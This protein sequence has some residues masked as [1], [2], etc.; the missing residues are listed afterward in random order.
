[1]I[2]WEVKFIKYPITIQYGKSILSIYEKI[3]NSIYIIK[4]YLAFKIL[5]NQ[6]LNSYIIESLK[7]KYPDTKIIYNESNSFDQKLNSISI[8][9]NIEDNVKKIKKSNIENFI[10]NILVTTKNLNIDTFVEVKKCYESKLYIRL[11]KSKEL[12]LNIDKYQKSIKIKLFLENNQNL[13]LNIIDPSNLKFQDIDINYKEKKFQIKNNKLKICAKEKNE[14]NISLKSENFIKNG[15]WNL[16]FNEDNKSKYMKIPFRLNEKI[17]NNLEDRDFPKAYIDSNE[18]EPVF[19]IYYYPNYEEQLKM[20]ENIFKF[21]KLS[22]GMGI[23]FVQKDRLSEIGKLYSFRYIYKMQKYVK[24][25]QLTN[26]SQGIENGYTANEEIG[27]NYFKT[28]P[29]INLDGKGVVISIVNSGINYL[30][31]DFIYPDG[32]SKIL[33]LWDQTKD[34]NPPEGFSIGTEYTR[35]EIN[36]AIAEKNPNL[37]TDEEGIGTAL[38]GVCAGLGNSNKA[39]AGVAEGADLIVVK[40]K[41]IN[42]FYNNGTFLSGIDYSYKK[43][44]KLDM[45]IV[46]NITLGSNNLLSPGIGFMDNDLFYEY[47]VCEVAGAGNEGSGRTHTMGKINFTGEVKDIEVEVAEDEEE[48]AIDIWVDKPDKLTVLIIS[49][50][51]EESKTARV[52]NLN[53]LEGLFDLENTYY[54][55]WSTY[56]LYYSGQQITLINL[57]G[58]SKGIWK[59]RLIGESITSGNYHVYLPNYLLLK[60]G[61]KFREGNPNY[62]LT[63][64]SVYKD[65][66]C[67]GTY[68]SLNSGMWTESS[69]G[70]VIGTI[71]RVESPDLVAPG[72]N[73]IAPYG[74]DKYALVT[75][76]GVASSYTVGCIALIM[77]YVLFKENYK[78]K[79]VVQKIKTYLRAGAKRDSKIRY[80]DV[81][82][83][84]GV[85]DIKNTF[86]QIK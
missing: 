26:I 32:T 85:L 10:Y 68:N 37:S 77:E 51:G 47:R 25:V 67:V 35:E 71:G 29:N 53:V 39:Y 66:V 5:D 78:D 11:E 1:M 33:Y 84:Y 38:G 2:N 6:E 50:S 80:P 24:M 70:P 3:D 28:N 34:G 62:T 46:Q 74:N 73:I 15:T 72:V 12:K 65:S 21:Y 4:D 49:P 42:G 7:S 57:E 30:H 56:P 36:K 9:L 82:Y 69:R 8:E 44:K 40:L 59:I 19:I 27:V 76:S 20:L 14:I 31:P 23:L 43:A 61:T 63:Y 16:K 81:S 17:K 45:P 41:K 83:G 22:D 54:S 58:V 64:P 48:I 52:S 79:A 86:D 60:P 55:I 13:K 18:F 75:G